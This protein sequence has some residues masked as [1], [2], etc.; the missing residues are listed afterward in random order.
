MNKGGGC[1]KIVWFG[2]KRKVEF[3]SEDDPIIFLMTR[4]PADEYVKEKK[5]LI[6]DP[7]QV[8]RERKL[9]SNIN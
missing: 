5:N 8:G 9:F 1:E 3:S 2:M 7:R 6:T 4:N